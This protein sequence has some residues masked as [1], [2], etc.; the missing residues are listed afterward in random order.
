LLSAMHCYEPNDCE[1]LLRKLKD[2]SLSSKGKRHTASETQDMKSTKTF[3]ERHSKCLRKQFRSPETMRQNFDVWFCRWKVTS[4]SADHPAH[5]RLDPIHLC[6]SFTSETK[7]AVENCKEKAQCTHDP[8][9]LKPMH[10]TILPHPNSKHQLT[11]CLSLRGESK[12]ESFHDHS[13]NFANTGMRNS[14]ADN[15]N[16][17]GTAR[18][19]LAIHH[20]QSLILKPGIE[21][22]ANNPEVGVFMAAQKRFQPDMRRCFLSLTTLNC[23]L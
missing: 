3:R 20:K 12:L 16:L 11:E 1:R 8:L 7:E 14:L 5:G 2:G 22:P 6:P 23:S 4:S 10:D 17:M 13:G 9:P 19:N 21:N 15:L 18:H